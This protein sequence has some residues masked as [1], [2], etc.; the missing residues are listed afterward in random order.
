MSR[1]R[2]LMP[3]AS[4][5]LTGLLRCPPRTPL[6]SATKHAVAWWQLLP[7]PRSSRYLPLRELD[8]GNTFDGL[9]PASRNVGS[10]TAIPLFCFTF[11][12][13]E[14]NLA[15]TLM[16]VPAAR[17]GTATARAATRAARKVRRRIVRFSLGGYAAMVCAVSRPRD[18]RYRNRHGQQKAWTGRPRGLGA[19]PRLH[20]HVGVLRRQRR[21]RVDRHDRTRAR[22]R[23]HAAG[24]GRHVRAVHQRAAGGPRDPRPPRPGRAG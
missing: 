16:R 8:S 2:P 11:G 5:T 7:T 22:A 1:K 23:D 10:R 15:G 4:F 21:G 3:F 9:M 19:R 20:G 24:H 13:L 6:N 14:A 18:P 12:S 17:A